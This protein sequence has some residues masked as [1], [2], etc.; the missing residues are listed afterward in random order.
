[1]ALSTQTRR[2]TDQRP[3]P[4]VKMA[5][6]SPLADDA[7][8]LQQVR[9]VEALSRPFLFKLDLAVIDTAAQIST[10]PGEAAT[11]TLI[12]GDDKE[13]Y[14]SGQITRV[15][16]TGDALRIELR[17]WP[18]LLTLT[19]DCRIYQD[20]S[21]PEIIQLLAGETGIGEVDDQLVRTY[22]KRDYCVQYRESGL[23][24][25]SRLMEECGITYGFAHTA[26]GHKLSLLDD[27]SAHD[28]LG[29]IEHLPAADGESWGEDGVIFQAGLAEAVATAEFGVEDYNFETPTTAINSDA[30]TGDWRVYE[31][32]AR[33]STKA[34]AE[35]IAKDRLQEADT[36]RERLHGASAVREL[37]AG[38]KFTLQ[39]HPQSDLNRSWLIVEVHHEAEAGRYRNRFEAIP[40]D[41]PYRPPRETPRPV[42]AGIQTAKV[43]GP[44]GKEI[45]TDEFGRICVKFHWDQRTQE[46]ETCSCWIRVAQVWAGKGWGGMVLPRI[47]QEVVVAFLEGDPDRPLVTG[48]VFNGENSVP[49]PLGDEATKTLLKTQ[50][51]PFDQAEG[52]G[53]NELAFEDK[54]GE[55]LIGFTAQ[56]DMS[57]QITN[58]RTTTLDKGND[59]LTLSEGNRT[60]E[61]TKG[62]EETTIKG[63]RKFTVDGAETHTNKADVTHTIG[64]NATFDVGGN[65]T[66]KAGG[67]ITIEAGGT[68]T[69]KAGT[70]LSAKAGTALSLDAGTELSGKG[71]TSLA[72]EGAMM[73]IKGASMG[74]IDGGGM[75]TVKGGLVKIN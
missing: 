54:A 47:G 45:W 37:A 75:L 40:G 63:T 43:V 2:W 38:R 50:T 12:S 65:I 74:T 17:P 51:S 64:G 16:R 21:V 13:R 44:S 72:M 67:N 10:L 30:G 7:L 53:F 57:F 36:E 41:I 26:S 1:M 62:N 49:Y 3:S 29:T 22:A 18:W 8:V 20:Q 52:E 15:V 39:N 32:P 35:A 59:K 56:K 14:I 4:P 46:D 27:P 42:I 9:G 33:C 70:S 69:L 71:G 66:I 68:L 5:F 19:R 48:C 55:E 11:L 34:D 31:Y 6:K 24:F 25:I 28:D 61:L 58:D 73:E 60:V 23:A